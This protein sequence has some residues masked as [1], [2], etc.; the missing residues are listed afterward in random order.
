MNAPAPAVET[1]P[2]RADLLAAL[3]GLV[4][5]LERMR[6]DLARG[7]ARETANA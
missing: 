1:E 7:I 2:T 6:A 4:V 3:E 5:S